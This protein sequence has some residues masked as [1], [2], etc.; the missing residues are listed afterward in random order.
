MPKSKKAYI[1]RLS[2]YI[3]TATNPTKPRKLKTQTPKAQNL[4]Q[5]HDWTPIDLYDWLGLDE[6]GNIL[7]PKS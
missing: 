5:T 1:N 6:D 2:V 3:D 7:P 4:S